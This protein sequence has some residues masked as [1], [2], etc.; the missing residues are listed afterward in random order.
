VAEERLKGRCKRF[1]GLAAKVARLQHRERLAR[2]VRTMAFGAWPALSLAALA[3][4]ALTGTGADPPM[5]APVAAEIPMEQDSMLGKPAD[6]SPNPDPFGNASLPVLSSLAS[7]PSGK[8][9]SI[10]PAESPEGGHDHAPASR[11]RP[12]DGIARESDADS[13]AEAARAW[14]GAIAGLPGYER[15]KNAEAHLSSL[16]PGRHGWL[17]LVK[18]DGLTVGHMVIS[19]KP[20]GGFLLAVFGPGEPPADL[21]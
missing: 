18:A 5:P 14:I 3:L 6:G 20:E 13:A 1:A 2:L 9:A 21:P 7:G 17:A 10:A 12:E 15:W 11:T 8:A 16:G 4:A 19:A